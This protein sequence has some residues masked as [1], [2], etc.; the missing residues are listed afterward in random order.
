M[1]DSAKVSDVTRSQ[2]SNLTEEETALSKVVSQ[3]PFGD[4]EY[5]SAIS[6]CDMPIAMGALRQLIIRRFADMALL[7][8]ATL[9]PDNPERCKRMLGVLAIAREAALDKIT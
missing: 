2:L 7:T 9:L 4:G 8:R 3:A 5:V 1:I 6:S